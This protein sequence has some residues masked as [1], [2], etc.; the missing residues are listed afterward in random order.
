MII[1]LLS[2]CAS[3]TYDDAV[4]KGLE[5]IEK[6]D[7]AQAVSYFEIAVKEKGDSAEAKTYLEQAT[8]LNKVAVSLKEKEYDQALRTILQIE[9]SEEALPI[10]KS[11]ASDLKG[12]ITEGQQNLAYEEELKHINSLLDAENYKDAQSKYET[13]K[14]ILGANHDFTEQFAEISK[15][16]SEAKEEPNKEEPVIVENPIEGKQPIS[17]PK[18]DF[19][20]QTYTNSRFGFSVQHPATFSMGEPPANNDGRKFSNGEASIKAYASH[21]NVIEENETIETYY[22]QALGDTAGPISYQRLG[23]DWYVISYT[24]GGNTIYEKAKMGKG[25]I[26][27]FIIEYPANKQ[28]LYGPMVDHISKTFKPGQTD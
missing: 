25:I 24:N 17:E 2:A 26:N 23:D 19:T 28:S 12:Q 11:S 6:K 15:R 16:L 20:Y 9:Q 3:K 13:L 7:F 22:N 14:K 27:T 4:E 5:S 18:A 10:V 1:L 8:L 21:I